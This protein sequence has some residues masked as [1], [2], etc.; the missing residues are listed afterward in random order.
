VTSADDLRARSFTIWT[1][2]KAS[3]NGID[4]HGEFML[5]IERR[6]GEQF[7]FYVGSSSH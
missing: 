1:K 5:L 6:D 3:E 7:E 4:V 2:R